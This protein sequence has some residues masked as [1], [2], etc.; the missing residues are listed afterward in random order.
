[1]E[2]R[3]LAG[4]LTR[5]ASRSVHDV[6]SAYLKWHSERIQIFSHDSCR[7]YSENQKLME[8]GVRFFYNSYPGAAQ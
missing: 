5:P 3:S 8:M 1:M 4:R 6:T 7:L 2:N